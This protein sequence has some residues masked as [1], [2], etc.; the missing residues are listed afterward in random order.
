MENTAIQNSMNMNMAILL[1]IVL[2]IIF[3]PCFE[4]ANRI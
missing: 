3:V 2:G 1:V 4:M